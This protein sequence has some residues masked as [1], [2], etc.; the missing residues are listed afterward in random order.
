[1]SRQG[2]SLRPTAR[3]AVVKLSG[4][5]IH[6]GNFNNPDTHELF[7][8]VKARWLRA[9]HRLTEDVL[10]VLHEGRTAG[11]RGMRSRSMA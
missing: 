2:P 1:M 8:K 4:R 10:R 9:G 3:G 6:F 5:S 7:G 11:G